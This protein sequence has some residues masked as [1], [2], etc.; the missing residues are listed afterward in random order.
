MSK[1]QQKSP[2]PRLLPKRVPRFPSRLPRGLKST[3]RCDDCHRDFFGDTC[4][5]AHC[6]KNHTGK[7][8]ACHQYT[9]C[10][11]RRQCPTCF[12]LEVGLEDNQ[13]HR[14]GYIECPS[15]HEYVD[16]QTHRYY[17]QRALTPH[18]IREQ[19]K[20]KRKRSRQG[21]PRAKRGPAA[22][23]QTFRANELEEEEEDEYEEDD[24]PPL[25][26]EIDIEAMQPQEQHVANLVVA[27]TE[28]NDWPLRF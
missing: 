13:R 25:H 6:T 17:L 11:R 26:I 27:E 28:D 24:I 15:C 12:K 18:E 21:G 23:L 14:C 4:Y 10:F 1:Q 22:G 19:K 9:I 20:K 8:A 5:E 3:R 2:V 7:P 16:A